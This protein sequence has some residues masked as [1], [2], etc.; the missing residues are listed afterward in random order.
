MFSC[1]KGR[2]LRMLLPGS[3]AVAHT[4]IVR[5]GTVRDP[6]AQTHRQQCVQTGDGYS[7]R[8]VRRRKYVYVV[9]I[10]SGSSCQ[11]DDE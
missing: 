10:I 6:R 1:R 11:G 4:I 9:D 8:N 7:R 3:C 5:G 2:L